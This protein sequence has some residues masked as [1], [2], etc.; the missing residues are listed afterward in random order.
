[1]LD[2][3]SAA[4]GYCVLRPAILSYIMNELIEKL[5]TSKLY[6]FSDWKNNDIPSVCAGVY[7]IYESNGEFLYIGM[8]GAALNQ[9]KIEA[10][11]KEKKKS[12]LQDRLGSHASGYRSG[13]RFNIYIG[14]LY[15]LKTL[16][17]TDI[18]NIS[19]R[20]DS[21]DSHIKKYIRQ[22]L[23]FRYLITRHDQVREL[24]TYIQINGINNVL[25]KINA[26]G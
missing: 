22:N 8:A 6:K 4:F 25:P 26:K 10:M 3:K 11:Q 14:D 20:L 23:S 21:F 19:K 1:M 17:N 18:D 2:R 9:S 24:E 12:G 16:S 13:D 15:V 7:S 5:S